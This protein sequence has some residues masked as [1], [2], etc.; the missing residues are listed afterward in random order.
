MSLPP[1]NVQIGADT[2][3]LDDGLS[4]SLGTLKRFAGAAGIGLVL[5]GLRNMVSESMQVI[6]AQAKLAR[7][8]GGTTAGLQALARAGDRAGVQQGELASATTRL[9]QRLGQVI[10]TG[11]G[12]DDTFKA[13]GLT[14]HELARMDVDERFM[15]ISDAMKAAGMSSQEMSFHLRELGIRQASVISLVQQGSE[16]ILRS[17][18]ALEDFGVAVS[19][20]DAAQIERANDALSE[21]GRVAEGLRNQIAIGMAPA[22]EMMAN[23]F[24]DAAMEGGVVHAVVQGLVALIPRL[25]T[26]LGTA[27]GAIAVYTTGLVALA[28]AKWA[29]AAATNGLRVALLRLGLPALIILTGEL[30]HQ[31]MRLV[32]SAG[33]FGEALEVLGRIG[34]EVFH[35][36]QLSA[37]AMVPSM[38]AVW[39]DIQAGF[40]TMLES[41]TSGFARFME[42]FAPLASLPDFGVTAPFKALGDVATATTA[43]VDGFSDAATSAAG[44]ADQL[45]AQASQLASAGVGAVKDSLLELQDIMNRDLTIPGLGDPDGGEGTGLDD[46]GDAPIAPGVGG[47]GSVTDDLEKRLEAVRQGLLNEQE[48]INEWYEEGLA[49]LIEARER[50]LVTEQEF[51]EAKARLQQE[52]ADKSTEIAKKEADARQRVVGG[53]LQNLISLQNT[54]SKKMFQIGKAAAVAQA[55]LAGREAIVSSYAA[56]A[57]IGGPPLGAAYA[58]TAAAATA[59][60]IASVMSTSLGGGGSSGGGSVSGGGGSASTG[61]GATQQAAQSPTTT[62]AFTIQNDPMGFGEQFARQM[63]EQLNEAQANGGNIR[64]VMG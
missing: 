24:T 59:G 27:A 5:R 58:A 63:I 7:S 15:A 48:V 62:F 29:A 52:Y 38:Q 26:Y 11:K 14:A 47:A 61:G 25:A 13:L 18:K 39:N 16:E 2:R 10:A 44:K 9:N 42:M 46:E 8:V 31:F 60:Q 53:M 45:R 56:G 50:E 3:G 1:L 22:I 37:Q 57:K 55:L 12:A 36:L 35:G 23:A 41:M 49:T 21:V 17:R 54:G 33:G 30:I 19:E 6:D 34:K 43:A 64:G 4:K 20:I 28:A 32:E 40:F 51:L